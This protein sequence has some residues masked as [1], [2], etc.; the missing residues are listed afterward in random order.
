LTR[1]AVSGHR[2]LTPQVET[3]IR[4]AIETELASLLAGNEEVV[5]LSCL[6]DGADQ[7]FASAVTDHGGSLEVI[8]PAEEYRTDLPDEAKPLYDKLF[9]R[10]T[11]VYRCGHRE[12]TPDAHMDASRLMVDRAD[13]LLAVWDGKPARSY[14]GTADVVAYA[15]Q[16]N[17]PVTVVWPHG[18]YR[19]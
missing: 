1:I 18:A 9:N 8:I 12:S 13:R 4:T 17:V 16:Q 3:L 10:A 15:E 2:G 11:I 14:G 6:A 5:G 7:I 19:E